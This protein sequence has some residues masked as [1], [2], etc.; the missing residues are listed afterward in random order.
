ML[1]E[2]LEYLTTPAS[3]LARSMGF[4][5]SSIQ[6]RA[7]FHRCRHHWQPHLENTRALILKAAS[8]CRSRRKVV[9]LGGGLL[10]DIPLAELSRLFEKVVLVDI[11]HPISSRITAW[12]Y[13]NVQQIS[14]DITDVMAH[15]PS[16]KASGPIALPISAP[17]F[18]CDDSVLDL[19]VS[20]NLL[21]QL[22]WVSGQ[23]LEKLVSPEQLE[24]FQHQLISA[25]L[26]YLTR[27]P[28]HT[29]LITDAEWSRT[30]TDGI[31]CERWSVIQNTALPAPEQEWI[32]DIAPAPERESTH[33]YSA[34]V[35]AYSDWKTASH[36]SNL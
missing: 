9:L 3:R 1:A 31:L 4:L 16:S 13:K 23:R 29:A 17:Q 12:P 7:R 5:K 22:G 36:S 2:L 18:F 27:L 6:V 11:V 35:L 33:D 21:S 32:W 24:T 15:L 20:V 14:L 8:L 30:T 34:K 26:D 19:T 25:H 28:G 10:H